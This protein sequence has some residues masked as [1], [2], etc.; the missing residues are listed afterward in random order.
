MGRTLLQGAQTCQ[1]TRLPRGAFD[2]GSHDSDAGLVNSFLPAEALACVSCSTCQEFHTRPFSA[3]GP[4]T[5]SG[6]CRRANLFVRRTRRRHRGQ[7]FHRRVRDLSCLI[8]STRTSSRRYVEV[9]TCE[10][11]IVCRTCRLSTVA[12]SPFPPTSAFRDKPRTGHLWEGGGHLE[13]SRHP[14]FACD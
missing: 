14:S 11:F 13:F 10:W 12:D 2:L 8:I 9:V 5:V 1:G 6:R 7:D 4:G 3:T